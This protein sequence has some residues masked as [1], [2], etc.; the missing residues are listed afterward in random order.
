M[1]GPKWAKLAQSRHGR[2]GA[3][4]FDYAYA[5]AVTEAQVRAWLAE[6]VMLGA[7]VALYGADC[8]DRTLAGYIAEQLFMTHGLMPPV[9]AGRR[10]VLAMLLRRAACREAKDWLGADAI[11]N[12]LAPIYLIEDVKWRQ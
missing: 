11:R 4:A 3:T 8:L 10:D 5:N 1:I 2:P 12:D 9:P 6:D 7:T